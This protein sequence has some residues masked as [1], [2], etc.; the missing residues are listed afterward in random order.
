MHPGP[1]APPPWPGNQTPPQKP[2]RTGLIIG[3]TSVGVVVVAGAIIGSMLLFGGQDARPS[4]EAEA[5]PATSEEEAPET[6]DTFEPNDPPS[7][8]DGDVFAERDAF[9]AEQQL[10]LDGTPLK[11]VTPEQ[12]AFIDEMKSRGGQW[13]DELEWTALALAMDACETSI[14]NSHNVDA[15]TVRMHAATSP[16]VADMASGATEAERIRITDG[17]MN[18]AATGVSY[19]CS[20]DHRDWSNALAEINGDW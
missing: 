11:A 9:F 13:S 14:L 5:A 6:T 7:N 8:F 10:P 12:H 15:D 3:L 18:I 16:L 4:K 1:G 20:A 2:R 17:A 19:I